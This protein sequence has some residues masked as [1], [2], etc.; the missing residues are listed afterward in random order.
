MAKH[1]I[2]W[3]KERLEQ[4][5][6]MKAR[7]QAEDMDEI[8]RQEEFRLIWADFKNGESIEDHL[9]FWMYVHDRDT[10]LEWTRD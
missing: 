9:E 2:K 7:W 8:E 1:K 4:A 3:T 5:T 10:F 6:A